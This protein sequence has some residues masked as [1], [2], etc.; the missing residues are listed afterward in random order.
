MAGLGL[1]PTDTLDQTIHY[2]ASASVTTLKE[3]RDYIITLSNTNSTKHNKTALGKKVVV[4]SQ[5]AKRGL[6]T[7]SDLKGHLLYSCAKIV[8]CTATSHLKCKIYT[9]LHPIIDQPSSKSKKKKEVALD[10]SMEGV[11]FIVLE[12]KTTELNYKL[13]IALYA[14]F[15]LQ[16]TSLMVEQSVERGECGIRDADG[17][18]VE[19]V[20]HKTLTPTE[21]VHPQEHLALPINGSGYIILIVLIVR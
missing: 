19:P 16:M 15:G 3:T 8:F 2:Q 5:G 10:T 17:V 9:S 14:C 1:L 4:G 21:I 13:C 18:I 6:L 12:S 11:D 7:L 20:D